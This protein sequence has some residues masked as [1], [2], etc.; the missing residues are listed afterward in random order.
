MS[1][2][3]STTIKLGGSTSSLLTIAFVILKLTGVITW[4]WFWVLFPTILAIG[5]GLLVL[6]FF[7]LLII[8]RLMYELR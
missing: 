5:S 3:K 6:F 1:N 8:I 4:S 2:N 7:L